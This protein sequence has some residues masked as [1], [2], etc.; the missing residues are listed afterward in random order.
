MQEELKRYDKE[1]NDK[2]V[3]C[4]CDVPFKSNFCMYF[5]NNFKRLRLKQL[6]CTSKAVKGGGCGYKLDISREQIDRLK[7][8]EGIISKLEGDGDFRSDECVKLLKQSDVLVTNPPFSLF[9]ELYEL[10]I[11]NGK[12]FILLETLQAMTYK[13]LFKDIK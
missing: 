3:Y 1:L 6:V 13:T 7:S 8:S 9:R 12:D 4:N 2:V 10:I 11:Q 5:L